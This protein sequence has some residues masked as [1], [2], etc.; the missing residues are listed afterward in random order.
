LGGVAAAGLLYI[1][2]RDETPPPAT[3]VDKAAP[4]NDPQ[5]ANGAGLRMDKA[6]PVAGTT[7][8]LK[9]MLPV[10]AGDLAKNLGGSVGGTIVAGIKVNNLVG[11]LTEKIAGQGAGDLAR[12]N[13]L[14]AVGTLTAKAAEQTLAKL[15]LPTPVQKQVSVTVGAAAVVGIAPAVAAKVAGEGAS[16][17]IKL[18]AGQKAERAVRDVV[19]QFD[20]TSSKSIVNKAIVKPI[21]SGVK[22]LGKIF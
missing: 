22:L 16:A 4:P 9:A 14:T 7:P 10:D 8:P 15:G 18:V 11:N 21:A 13:P 1:L 3:T 20:P 12:V 17:L 6:V 19:K 5:A 2:T